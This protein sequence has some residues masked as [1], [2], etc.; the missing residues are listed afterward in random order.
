MSKLICD[1]CGIKTNHLEEAHPIRFKTKFGFI[2]VPY[3]AKEMWC[4]N[5]KLFGNGFFRRH[6]EV[7]G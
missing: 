2:P 7:K 1:N 3:V 5:C 4:Y 6:L